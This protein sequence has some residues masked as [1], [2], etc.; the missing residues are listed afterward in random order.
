MKDYEVQEGF[1]YDYKKNV[2]HKMKSNLGE[3]VDSSF[4][5]VL[6]INLNT[7]LA[8]SAR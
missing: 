8:G 5:E 2:W 4:S 7:L 6:N 1:V 3:A